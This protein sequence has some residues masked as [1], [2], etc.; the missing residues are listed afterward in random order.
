MSDSDQGGEKELPATER[1]LRRL[2]DDGQVVQSRDLTAAGATIAVLFVLAAS[3]TGAAARLVESTRDSW[4]RAAAGEASPESAFVELRRALEVSIV[5]VV[6]LFVAAIALACLLQFAQVGFLFVPKLLAPKAERVDPI[7]GIIDRLIS[8]RG[9]LQA[10]KAVL[11]MVIV[12]AVIWLVVRGSIDRLIHSPTMDPW[13]S[14]R[15]AVDGAFEL[16]AWSGALLLVLG[17]AEFALEWARFRREHRMSRHERKKEDRESEGDPLARQRREQARQELRAELAAAAMRRGNPDV[18]IVNPTHIACALRIEESGRAPRI[19]ASGRGIVAERIREMA[20]ELRAPIRKDIRL[21]RK[22][23]V[24]DAG[25]PIPNDLIDAVVAV[26]R[27][28]I[29]QEQA[30]GRTPSFLDRLQPVATIPYKD[31]N[32]RGLSVDHD[33][34]ATRS[35]PST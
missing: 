25:S 10:G 1:K 32:D 15:V 26:Y 28:A 6:P 27:W 18:V 31:R 30:R 17:F 21:A 8:P 22:L 20:R 5:E 35:S 9:A 16:A 13:I 12:S 23:V 2:R 29:R 33:R 24:L 14:A 19:I 11:K 3:G 4:S 34:V 7:R